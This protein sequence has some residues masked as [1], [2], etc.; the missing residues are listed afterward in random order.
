MYRNTL[1]YSAGVLFRSTEIANNPDKYVLV[2]HTKCTHSS[3]ILSV[4]GIAPDCYDITH[5][6]EWSKTTEM[7]VGYMY[8]HAIYQGFETE[9]SRDRTCFV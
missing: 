1:M 5:K 8:Y 6:R 3:Y 2:S 9:M 4:F 7:E